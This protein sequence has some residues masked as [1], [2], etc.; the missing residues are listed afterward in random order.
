MH[1]LYGRNL[2]SRSQPKPKI[3]AARGNGGEGLDSGLPA[4]GRYRP[5]GVIRLLARTAGCSTSVPLS[6]ARAPTTSVLRFS[7][8]SDSNHFLVVL[9][10]L[11]TS[12]AL[13]RALTDRPAYP[14][15]F[16]V[17]PAP[18]NLLHLEIFNARDCIL[19]VL[20]PWLMLLAQLKRTRSSGGSRSA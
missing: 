11:P 14:P 1:L 12:A 20:K 6:A 9:L 7:G 15:L 5:Q 2:E 10:T 17:A 4:P 8:L 16:C 18:P 13:V 19:A 3:S